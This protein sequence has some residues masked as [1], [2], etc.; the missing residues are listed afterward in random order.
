MAFRKNYELKITYSP[1]AVPG[2][3]LR[4]TLMNELNEKETIQSDMK[5]E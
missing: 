2:P 4:T 1:L 3:W 5:K